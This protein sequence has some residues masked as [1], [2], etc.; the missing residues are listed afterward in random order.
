M[1]YAAILIYLGLFAVSL[2]LLVYSADKF[3]GASEQLGLVL[4]VPHFIMGITVLAVGTS[5]PELITAL[6]AVH[7]GNSE[8]V[9]GTVVGSNIANILFILGLTAILSNRFVITWDLLHGDLPMLFGSLLMLAFVV[10]PLSGADLDLFHQVTAKLGESGSEA[11]GPRAGVNWRESLLLLFGYALYVQYYAFRRKDGALANSAELAELAERPAFRW[12]TVF[13]IVA[14]LIGVLIGA[15]YTV[16]NAIA[17]ATGLGLGNEIIA[18]SL[19]ALGTSMPELVVS[20]SAAR[21]NNFEMALGNIT[22]S[23]IFN[24]FVV[25]G[26]PGLLSPLLGDHQPLRVGDE[27]VLFLQMPFYGATL[28]LFL[29]VMLDKQITRTEGWVIFTAYILFVCKLFNLL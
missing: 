7:D 3:V 27:S 26:L 20:I 12:R 18:A 29:V 16:D 8:I 1:D 2:A 19:I 25:L 10:Y 6:F 22:G 11:L 28:L 5:F 17:V 4:G 24:T 23:N 9:I 21:R 13:W 14:G 15:K